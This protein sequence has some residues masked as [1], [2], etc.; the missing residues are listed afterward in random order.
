MQC[1]IMYIHLDITNLRKQF[2]VTNN[3]N[4]EGEEN[5]NLTFHLNQAYS[6]H[7]LNIWCITMISEVAQS[8]AAL[9]DP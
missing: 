3:N 1:L 7:I 9:C 2:M 5:S 4:E 8:C 6:C